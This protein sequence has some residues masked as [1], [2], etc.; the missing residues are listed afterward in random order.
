M[1]NPLPTCN[2]SQAPTVGGSLSRQTFWPFLAFVTRKLLFLVEKT[3]HLAITKVRNLILA[4]QNV[5]LVITKAKTSE[6]SRKNVW[7]SHEMDKHFSES[8]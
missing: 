1:N 2:L 5:F 8:F 4:L 7:K 3:M 6:I